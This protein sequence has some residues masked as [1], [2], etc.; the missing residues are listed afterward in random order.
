[1]LIGEELCQTD[2]VPVARRKG[3]Y[4]NKNLPLMRLRLQPAGLPD[5]TAIEITMRLQSLVFMA[6]R[7]ATSGPGSKAMRIPGGSF[8]LE[9]PQPPPHSLGFSLKNLCNTRQIQV[10]SRSKSIA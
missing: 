7:R 8:N 5:A 1:M 3:I 9:S 10:S 6:H 2:E 4:S